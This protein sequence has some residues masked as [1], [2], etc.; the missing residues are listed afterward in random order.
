[1]NISL[2]IKMYL[3]KI[4]SMIFYII[5]KLLVLTEIFLFLRLAL[6]FFSANPETFIVNL[7]YKST[8]I[9]I[10]PF[11]SIFPDI[12]WPEGFLIETATISAMIGYL[13]GVFIIF[14]LLRLFS[15]NNL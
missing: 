4:Y 8:D 11:E 2:L 13:M 5:K 12:H 9:I 14:Q 15:R 7:I 10:L 6:K 3:G 1:M